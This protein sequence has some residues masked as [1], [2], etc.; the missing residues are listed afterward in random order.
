MRKGIERNGEER[1]LRNNALNYKLY[2]LGH[3]LRE[4]SENINLL[5]IMF[6]TGLPVLDYDSGQRLGPVT[7]LAVAYTGTLSY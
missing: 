7:Y 5:L 1:F 2:P 3:S 4:A 6:V